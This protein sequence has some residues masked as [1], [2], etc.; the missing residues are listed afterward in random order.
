MNKAERGEKWSRLL[1]V[2][3]ELKYSLL[4]KDILE[5]EAEII[6]QSVEVASLALELFNDA[7]EAEKK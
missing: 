2:S 7:T 3:Q 5:M 1:A 6:S 4:Y